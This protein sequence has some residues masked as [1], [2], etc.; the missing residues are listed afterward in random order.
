MAKRDKPSDAE[1][2]AYRLD[3]NE[4]WKQGKAAW[5]KKLPVQACPHGAG[6]R[7]PEDGE[8]PLHVGWLFG[9]WEEAL[10]V[11]DDDA[12]REGYAAGLAGKKA[13]DC[14][15]K[16]RSQSRQDYAWRKGFNRADRAL[17]ALRR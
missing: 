14:P 13:A 16:K 6:L 4:G 9:W 10:R 3:L 15:F 8:G 1:C 2:A 11:R 7:I 12:E 5:H 17:R